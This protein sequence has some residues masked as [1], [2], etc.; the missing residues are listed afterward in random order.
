MAIRQTQQHIYSILAFISFSQYEYTENLLNTTSTSNDF[1]FR[2]TI[3]F[4]SL[5]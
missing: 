2:P 3:M 5:N 4:L 1:T